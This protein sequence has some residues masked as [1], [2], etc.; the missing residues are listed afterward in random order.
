MS[1]MSTGSTS[2]QVPDELDGRE[3]RDGP[4]PSFDSPGGAAALQQDP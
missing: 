3:S 2:H 1:S 4:R